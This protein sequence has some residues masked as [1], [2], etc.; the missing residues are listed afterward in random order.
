[1][2]LIDRNRNRHI[3]YNY[4]QDNHVVNNGQDFNVVSVVNSSG[5]FSY[6]YKYASTGY[7]VGLLDRFSPLSGALIHFRPNANCGNFEVVASH[8][9]EADESILSLSLVHKWVY[10]NPSIITGIKQRIVD[11]LESA[12]KSDINITAAFIDILGPMANF[13]GKLLGYSSADSLSAFLTSGAYLLQQGKAIVPEQALIAYDGI[14][15]QDVNYTFRKTYITITDEDQLSSIDKTINDLRYLGLFPRLLGFDEDDFISNGQTKIVHLGPKMIGGDIATLLKNYDDPKYKEYLINGLASTLIHEAT[16]KTTFVELGFK[17]RG[18]L[19]AYQKVVEDVTSYIENSTRGYKVPKAPNFS[20]LPQLRGTV[21]GRLVGASFQMGIE[22]AAILFIIAVTDI[23]N[24]NTRPLAYAGQKFLDMSDFTLDNSGHYDAVLYDR[25]CGNIVRPDNII[26]LDDKY[27]VDNL[28]KLI[29]DTYAKIYEIFSTSLNGKYPFSVM[30]ETE[31][32]IPGDSENEKYYFFN[33]IVIDYNLINENEIDNKVRQYLA[34]IRTNPSL[35]EFIGAK[36][37]EHS[38]LSKSDI[39]FINFLRK[40]GILLALPPGGYHFVH[41]YKAVIV[42]LLRGKP[43]LK[44]SSPSDE[45]EEKVYKINYYGFS[46]RNILRNAFADVN[47]VPTIQYMIP[48]NIQ[49]ENSDTYVYSSN[50]ER[51]GDFGVPLWTRLTVTMGPFND[52]IFFFGN[53]VGLDK[54]AKALRIDPDVPS[55]GTAAEQPGSGSDTLTSPQNISAP[56]TPG[57]TQANSSTN[58][59]QTLSQL[60]GNSGSTRTT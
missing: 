5:L 51:Y 30:Q 36:A 53:F 57:G 8:G 24:K 12:S 18:V 20:E 3:I 27:L 44:L 50:P 59:K 13:V 45:L 54:L 41:N 58:T 4:L 39:N 48:I 10:N 49:V 17:S 40:F 23:C 9:F 7:M 55:T 32:T 35:G 25:I 15:M 2:P 34:I 56:P 1:M 38:V 19:K 52:W 42:A 43:C 11:F 26:D 16:F 47:V 28:L 6:R 29:S 46:F 22:H 14:E 37:L 33:R 31:K 21:G 60:L